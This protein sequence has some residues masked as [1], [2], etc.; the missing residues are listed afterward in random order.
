[1]SAATDRRTFLK[2]A[3]AAGTGFIATAHDAGAETRMRKYRM[4]GKEVPEFEASLAGGGRITNQ[5]FN[6]QWSFVEFWGLW[7]G[8]CLLDAPYV[9]AMVRTASEDPEVQYISFHL[10]KNYGKWKSVEA[11]MEENEISYPVILDPKASVMA[12]FKL[13]ATPSY[14]IVGPD[15]IIRACHTSFGDDQPGRDQFALWMKVFAFLR[16]GGKLKD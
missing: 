2:L 10:F 5:K 6:G 11:Y 16:A 1:M 12:K 9:S 8:P 3:A 15:R 13:Q 4:I 14:L 7:C